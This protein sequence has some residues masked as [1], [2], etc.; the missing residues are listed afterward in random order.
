MMKTKPLNIFMLIILFSVSACS[1]K[2][3]DD[4]I[5]SITISTEQTE[6]NLGG[7]F[8]FTVKDN[9][10]KSINSDVKI[11]VNNI[12]IIGFTFQPDVPGNF[13]VYAKYQNFTSNVLSVE[14]L[15][16]SPY[17]QKVLIEDYTGTWCGWCPRVI[18]AIELTLAQSQDVIP[19]AIHSSNGSASDPFN[20]AEKALLFSTFS[21][22]GYP[23]AK[24]NRTETWEYPENTPGGV[25]QVV[26][27]LQTRAPLGIGISS[28]L[29]NGLLNI[30]VEVEFL[31]DQSNLNL[32]VYLLEDKL[33]ANQV[34][35]YEDLYGGSNPLVNLEHNHVLRHCLT[36]LLGDA[37]SASESKQ[38]N[39]FK[40]SFNFTTADSGISNTENIKVVAFVVNGSTKK[41]INVQKAGVNESVP[42]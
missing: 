12:E 19:V 23:T 37:I 6:I 40:K 36:H 10:G 5:S 34:N 39:T 29:N 31:H 24:I 2:V 20:F 16:P 18:N 30:D 41:V 27:K 13:S 26:K 14:V 22:T 42:L 3:A 9:F 8:V 33:K 35:Y 1:D 32:V 21:V 17:T 7:T 38:N 4:T 25:Y 11:Y 28:V 15:A